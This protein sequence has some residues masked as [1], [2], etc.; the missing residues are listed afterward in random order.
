[1]SFF[2]YFVAVVLVPCGLVLFVKTGEPGWLVSAMAMALVLA[3]FG[4]IL[5]RLDR[6]ERKLGD[7]LSEAPPGIHRQAIAVAGET[8]GRQS[9]DLEATI[10]A[11]DQR[12]N[13]ARDIVI[14]PRLG[15]WIRPSRDKARA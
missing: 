8:D 11:L 3:A 4:R 9:R 13:P 15:D 10:A 14:G 6:I 7:L 5:R 1:M 12:M 2:A